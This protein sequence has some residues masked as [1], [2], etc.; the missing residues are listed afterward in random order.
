MTGSKRNQLILVGVMFATWGVVFLDRMTQLY[1]APYI[2]SDLHLSGTQ[3]GLITSITAMT[4]AISSL[5]FGALS[6]RVGRKRV[7]LPMVLMFAAISC[8]SGAA[9]GFWDLMILRGLMGIA[10]GPCWSVIVALVEQAS[11]PRHRGR[12]VGFVVS[13][14]AIVGQFVGPVLATQVA[15]HFGWRAAFIAAGLPGFI[16]ALLIWRFVREPKKTVAA[17]EAAAATTAWGD[18]RVLLRSRNVWLCCLGSASFIAWLMLQNL[19]APLYIV[20]VVHQPATTAGFLLSA[21]GIGTIFVGYV[22][23][24]LMDRFGRRPLL[25]ALALLSLVSP[26]ALLILPLYQH[27]SVLTV[28][29]FCTQGGLGIG[30]LAM[31]LLPAESV[32]PRLAGAAIGLVNLCGELVGGALLPTIAGHLSETVGTHAPLVMA[33]GAMATLFVVTLLLSDTRSEVRAAPPE[34]TSNFAT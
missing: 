21:A 9:R 24:L 25:A 15:T 18:V 10:E 1:L 26:L 28:I 8:L 30:P 31:V 14:G 20:K 7:L 4:W 23:V 33:V 17:Q 2:V 5:V 19:F 16:A 22:S 27:L 6:D 3:I 32:P 12:N 11:D 29:L 34:P 13:A